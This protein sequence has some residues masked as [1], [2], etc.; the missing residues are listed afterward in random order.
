[1]L[2]SKLLSEKQLRYLARA[3]YEDVHGLNPYER[4]NIFK[5]GQYQCDHI[6]SGRQFLW[7]DP[8]FEDWDNIYYLTPYL[9]KEK[10]GYNFYFKGGFNEKSE[11][12]YFKKDTKPE[13]IYIKIA[14][15]QDKIENNS[16]N[17]L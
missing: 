1:M 15:L 9:E 8:D 4:K 6:V 16:R 12:I 14:E 2:R 7:D 17:L 10:G 5:Y 11:K 13:D 3:I